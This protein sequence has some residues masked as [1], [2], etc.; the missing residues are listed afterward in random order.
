MADFIKDMH[1]TRVKNNVLNFDFFDEAWFY[2][3]FA[4]KYLF[5]NMLFNIFFYPM[6]FSR[7]CLPHACITV[8][9]SDSVSL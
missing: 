8:I 1:S 4:I 6:T 7:C 5:V 2:E 9:N 3:A